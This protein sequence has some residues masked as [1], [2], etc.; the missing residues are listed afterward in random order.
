[1]QP[2]FKLEKLLTRWADFWKE[3]QETACLDNDMQKI[4]L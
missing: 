2:I 1:M 4:D 3:K